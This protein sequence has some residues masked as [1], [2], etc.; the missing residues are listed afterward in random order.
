MKELE[1]VERQIAELRQSLDDLDLLLKQP[2]RI[3]EYVR[4]TDTGAVIYTYSHNILGW[5]LGVILKEKTE[6][7]V[8]LFSLE[9]QER[10]RDG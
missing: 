1:K 9:E 4:L 2:E 7:A 8:R 6:E 10:L 3:P 5:I